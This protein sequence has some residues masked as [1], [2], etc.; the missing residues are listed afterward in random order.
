MGKPN[1]LHGLQVLYPSSLNSRPMVKDI[2]IST[3]LELLKIHSRVIIHHYSILVNHY[4]KHQLQIS[5]KTMR[6]IYSVLE[7]IRFGKEGQ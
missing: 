4:A 2:P 3:V 1:H 5:C 7:K 6:S